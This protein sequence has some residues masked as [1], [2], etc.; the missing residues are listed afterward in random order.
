M[1]KYTNKEIFEFLS[2]SNAIEG[3]YGTLS[4][5]DA[6]KAWDYL[7][8]KDELTIPVMLETHR[9]LMSNQPLP[10]TEIGYFRK[11]PVWIGG[12][13]GI[14]WLKIQDAI[15]DWLLEM[16][17]ISDI[18]EKDLLSMK[19]HVAY[20]K[21][22]PHTDGNGRTGRLYMNWWRWKNGL[23][24]LIIHEGEEQDSY[25]SWFR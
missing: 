23:P 17:E 18:K 21:I 16:N 6:R 9:L 8:K 7:I 12:R 5:K 11:V 20:E 15:L 14:F 1:K 25:Y 4:Y 19:L 10:P 2:E 13:E 3:V 22:H 24:I